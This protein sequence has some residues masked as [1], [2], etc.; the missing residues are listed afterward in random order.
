MKTRRLVITALFAA[1][2]FVSI[3]FFHIPNGLGGVIHFGDALIFIAATMLPFPYAIAAAA[4]GA[5]L[6]NLV[7]VPIWLPF[8]I[9]IKPLMTLCFNSSDNK[10]F[11][12]KKNIIAPFIAAAINTVLYFGANWILFDWYTAIGAFLP[13]IIQGIGSVIFYFIIAFALDRIEAKKLLKRRGIL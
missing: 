10:I 7:R 2:I 6:F 13:L 12:S 3:L 9:V 5:G 8:T 1:L 11:N 4:L